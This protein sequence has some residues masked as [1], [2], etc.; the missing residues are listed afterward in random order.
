MGQFYFERGIS[1]SW[2]DFSDYLTIKVN[3]KALD[4]SQDYCLLQKLWPDVRKWAMN[5]CDGD[6]IAGFYC[7]ETLTLLFEKEE[8]LMAFKLRWL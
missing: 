8:D 6:V 1:A 3:Y 7:H 2:F 5:N 4:K